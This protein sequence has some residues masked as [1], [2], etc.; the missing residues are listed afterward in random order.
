MFFPFPVNFVMTSRAKRQEVVGAVS[1]RLSAFDVMHIQ[2][3]I[4]RLAFTMLA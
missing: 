1:A 2:D 4:F 3:L